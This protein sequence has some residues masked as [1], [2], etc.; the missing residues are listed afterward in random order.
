MFYFKD[1]NGNTIYI[2]RKYI[3]SISNI[4]TNNMDSNRIQKVFGNS[5]TL[6]RVSYGNIQKGYGIHEHQPIFIDTSVFQSVES[7]DELI[8]RY[9]KK[10][11]KWIGCMMQ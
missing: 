2:K 10:D 5:K 7:Q 4:N 8:N 9:I 6:I 11:S 3:V 1:R